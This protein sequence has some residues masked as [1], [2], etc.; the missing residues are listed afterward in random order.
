MP[1]HGGEGHTRLVHLTHGR[2]VVAPSSNKDLLQRYQVPKCTTTYAQ[3][4]GLHTL[5]CYGYEVSA[6]EAKNTHHQGGVALFYVLHYGSTSWVLT[7]DLMRQ[8]WSF[9]RR[10][11]Q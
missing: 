4:T 7:G 10:C 3:I 5:G 11:C 8:L 1:G 2:G 6:T 9:H